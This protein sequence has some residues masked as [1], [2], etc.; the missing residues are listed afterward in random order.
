MSREDVITVQGV[1]LELLPNTIFKVKLT[2]MDDTI[3]TAHIS[4][5]IRKNKI[6]IL[7]GDI[8]EI[9][10][11]PYDLTKGRISRRLK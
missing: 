6:R 5:K 10:M 9:E 2:D 3:I 1:V 8:V 7:K 11:T 4:G